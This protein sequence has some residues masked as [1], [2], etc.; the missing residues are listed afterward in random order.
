[1]AHFVTGWTV[2]DESCARFVYFFA[3]YWLA[4]YVFALSDRARGNPVAAII[5]LLLWAAING[6]L[7]RYGF[8]ELP[9]MSLLLGLAGACAVIVVGT[10]LARMR[11]LDLLRTCGENSIVIYLA[12]FLPMAATRTL[13]LKSGLIDDV[14]LVSLIVTIVGVAGA[15]VIWRAA[16]AAH[17]NFLFERPGA[18]WIAPKKPDA[19]LQA[20]E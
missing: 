17:A 11:W 18:F 3:G 16:L 10:L 4:S 6:A 19:V 9:L 1:M 7:V 8:S 2:I 14:G 13:L 12:F 15:L 20:A 5:G